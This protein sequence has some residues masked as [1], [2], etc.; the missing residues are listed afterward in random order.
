V[1]TT[2]DLKPGDIIYHDGRWGRVL[3]NPGYVVRNMQ[4]IKWEHGS[5]WERTRT[6]IKHVEAK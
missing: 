1:K 4:R 3:D 2:A 6:L 5:F